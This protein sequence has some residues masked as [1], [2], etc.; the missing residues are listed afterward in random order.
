MVLPYNRQFIE[1]LSV[2]VLATKAHMSVTNLDLSIL[3]HYLGRYTYIPNNF[4][5]ILYEF[6]SIYKRYVR[7]NTKNFEF[8]HYLNIQVGKGTI[9]KL[10]LFMTIP[11]AYQILKH[12]SLYFILTAI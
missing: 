5:Y 1:Q 6:I 10:Y 9:D 11:L 2:K 12:N 4:V 8:Y 3:V 7:R